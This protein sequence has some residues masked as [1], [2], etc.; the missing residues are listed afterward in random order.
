V[1]ATKYSRSRDVTSAAA[2]D[3][4]G[5]PSRKGERSPKVHRAADVWDPSVPI[6]ESYYFWN[7]D[8]VVLF[9]RASPPPEGRLSCV[10]LFSGPG[11]LSLGLSWAGFVPIL[12]I[13]IH[14]PSAET[15]IS[16]HPGAAFILGD[17]RRISNSMIEAATRGARVSLL[18]GG[19]PCQGFSLSNRKRWFND[20]RN[21]LFREFVRVADFLRPDAV[22]IENVSGLVS[23]KSGDFVKMITESLELAGPGYNVEHRLLAHRDSR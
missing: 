16:N 6:E 19:I 15:F 13:D 14:R 18:A 23:T 8:P 22:L 4:F 17:I 20:P 2:L 3:G 12:G 11:G 10:D 9:P 7:G 21:F 1:V 5:L